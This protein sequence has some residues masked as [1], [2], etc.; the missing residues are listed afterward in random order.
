LTR[1]YETL[2][3]PAHRLSP[4][5]RKLKVAFIGGRGVVSRYSGIETY[6]EEVGKRLVELGHDVTI[7]CRTYFTPPLE[8]YLGMRLLRLPTIRTKHLDTLIH[9]FISTVHACF[10]DY[11]IVQYHALG[12]A[13]FSFFPRLTGKKTIATVQGLDWQRKKWGRIASRILKVGER[14]AISFPNATIVVSRVLADYYRSRGH[15]IYIPNG[16]QLSALAPVIHLPEWG[17]QPG[18]YILFLGRFSPEKNCDLLIRAYERLKTDVK[19]V[20]AGGSS[21]S[22]HYTRELQTHA[23]DTTI[24]GVVRHLSSSASECSPTPCSSFSLRIW[25]DYP[26][27][28]WMPWVPACAWSPATFPRTVNWCRASDIH[29]P[30]ATSLPYPN[31]CAC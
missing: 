29:S 25:K 7:Y 15:P 24:R 31:C 28:C 8:N 16:T 3:A 30:W 18:N 26:W 13:L 6:Y 10:S 20:L 4:S 22:D 17:L 19:L 5:S 21:Y 14:A 1:I 2:I 27:L 12:P 23:S 9:T 11:D